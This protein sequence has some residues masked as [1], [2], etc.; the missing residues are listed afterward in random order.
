MSPK[1]ELREKAEM[2]SAAACMAQVA[3]KVTQALLP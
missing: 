2:E 1:E 3:N